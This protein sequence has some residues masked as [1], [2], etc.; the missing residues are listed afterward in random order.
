[1]RRIHHM[2]ITREGLLY[3][4]VMGT[5]LIAAVIR[6]INLLMLLYGVLAGPL[7]LSWSL[8][9]QTLKKIDVARKCPTA[10]NAG[11]TFRVELTATNNKRRGSSFSVSARDELK[12]R[13]ETKTVG[14]E[15]Y[16]PYLPVGQSQRAAYDGVLE[17]RGIYDFQPI[18]IST[19]FPLGMLRTMLRVDRPQRLIVLPR[20]GWLSPQW[21]RLWKAEDDAI[22][23]PRRRGGLQEGDFYGLREWRTGDARSRIHWRTTARRQTLTVRQY[24]R[25][26]QLTVALVVEAWMPAKPTPEDRR[27]LEDVLSFAATILVE[28]CRESGRT[29]DLEIIGKTPRNIHAPS[30]AAV[31]DEGLKA[32][33]LTE[34]T[35]ADQLPK[36]MAAMYGR[37]KP[38]T[39]VL[40]VSTRPTTLDDPQRFASMSGD[41][42]LRAWAARSAVL[43]PHDALWSQVF[44]QEASR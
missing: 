15:V 25:K 43:T 11:E 14:T 26:R 24:E 12:P 1:M 35:A 44:Q 23:G 40:V 36:T 42:E 41:S 33:A 37:V 22:G 18:K 31:V 6:Q 39:N 30:S 28:V 27:R 29:I 13:G 8:V 4:G 20:I 9:R 7:L 21:Q 3:L 34:S 38:G 32:L 10:V 17:Q 16:F 19:R 5:I 2:S